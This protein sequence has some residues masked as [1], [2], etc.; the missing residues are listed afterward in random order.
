MIKKVKG[1]KIGDTFWFE[2]DEFEI[3]GFRSRYTVFG[4]IKDYKPGGPDTCKVSIKDV[5]IKDKSISTEERYR[6]SK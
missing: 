4:K 5:V 3:T 6:V 2:D 1:I